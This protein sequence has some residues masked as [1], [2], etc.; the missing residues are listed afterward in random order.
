M[1]EVADVSLPSTQWGEYDYTRAN[2]ERRLRINRQFCDPPGE[3]RSD[4]LIVAQLARRLG[5]R[6]GSV[7]PTQW[8]F[9]DH[10]SVYDAMRETEEGRAL[11]LNKLSRQ[12]LVELGTNGIQIPIVERSGSL[13][14]TPRIYAE[15]FDTDDG[16]ARFVPTDQSWTAEDPLAFLPDEI[17]PD[18]EH[19]FFVT[20][21]RY[22]AVWQSGYTYRWTTDLA[23]QVRFQ[24]I[25]VHPDDADRL[26]IGSADWVE[27]SNQ[28]GACEGLALVSDVCPPGVVSAIFAWQGPSDE[29]PNGEPRYYANNLIPGGP[30]LQESNA[31]LFKNTRARL[32]KLD[33]E[34]PTVDE[35]AGMS[36]T[37][38]TV[39][40]MTGRGAAGN[41]A[42][43]ARDRLSVPVRDAS[44]EAEGGPNVAEEGG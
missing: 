13:A 6:H 3:A 5:E 22:Q 12:R 34:R 7:D 44:P 33:R 15:R 1:T 30:L 32:R 19:P 37:D 8:A 29:N 9:E 38:R 20:T 14:G 41:P 18:A 28:Y 17:K 43:R 40:G 4:Y 10:A 42:S 35:A 27:L 31:A 36:F 23:K 16:R 26:G 24:E 25:T 2:L 39:D 11:G 21:V